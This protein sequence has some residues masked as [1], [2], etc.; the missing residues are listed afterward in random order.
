MIQSVTNKVFQLSEVTA[1]FQQEHPG[2]PIIKAY[3]TK[4][5][6]VKPEHLTILTRG[7]SWVHSIRGAL[8]LTHDALFCYTAPRFEAIHTASS[9]IVTFN[10]ITIPHV[11]IDQTFLIEIK[12]GYVLAIQL[13]DNTCF[14]FGL[15]RDPEL[16]QTLSFPYEIIKSKIGWSGYSIKARINCLLW[17]IIIIGVIVVVST[18]F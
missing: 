9:G 2:I 4:F 8:I 14:Q 13:K 16:K 7:E 1:R 15:N 5:I 18:I 6:Q 10:D 12:N 17:L 11:I 3:A